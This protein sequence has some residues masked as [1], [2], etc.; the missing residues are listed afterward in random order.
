MKGKKS[1][2]A[3]SGLSC[4][5]CYPQCEFNLQSRASPASLYCWME[6]EL[7]CDQW[8]SIMYASCVQALHWGFMPKLNLCIT[9]TFLPI[10]HHWW[11]QDGDALK[12]WFRYG[13][14]KSLCRKDGD[15]TRK[16]LAACAEV[17]TA[18]WL[19]ESVLGDANESP[20]VEDLPVLKVIC[21]CSWSAIHEKRE[22]AV[23]VKSFFFFAISVLEYRL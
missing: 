7:S 2:A 4:I 9:S 6:Y 18:S 12:Y 16:L 23:D 17:G 10:N 11:W 15:F 14:L 1:S 20:Q 22:G 5:A 8:I 21:L 3:E 13:Q 19:F